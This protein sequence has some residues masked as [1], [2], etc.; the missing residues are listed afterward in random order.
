MG[1]AT[2]GFPAQLIEPLSVEVGRPS[3]SHD[4]H[5]NE[6]PGRVEWEAVEG[7]LA[8]PGG[9]GDVGAERP[10]GVEVAMTFHFPR[11]YGRPLRG[12]SL[13]HI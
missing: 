7:V 5:G 1:S 12:L 4:A 8:H 11:G 13:I 2:T 3:R 6:V 9:T 10:D